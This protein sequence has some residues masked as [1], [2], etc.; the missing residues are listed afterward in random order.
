MHEQNIIYCLKCPFTDEIHYV[1]KSTQ[2][3]L[4]PAQHLTNSHSLK[5]KEWV[6]DIS[7][8]GYTPK[9]EILEKNIHPEELSDKEIYWIAK[10]EK[11][12]SRLLNK[13]YM[14]YAAIL[15]DNISKMEDIEKHSSSLM[16]EVALAIKG[17]RKML[18]ITQP[19]FSSK[20]GIGLRWLRKVESGNNEVMLNYLEKL[21]GS[22]GLKLSLEKI[23]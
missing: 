21:L 6:D 23:K 2:G 4:R 17:R 11:N 5:I 1:G 18:K 13:Q 3:M 7:T 8:F 16:K 9:I 20:L 12:G 19:E 10:C 22:L 14:T 15:N